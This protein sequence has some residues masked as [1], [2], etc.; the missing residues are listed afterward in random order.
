MLLYSFKKIHVSLDTYAPQEMLLKGFMDR[1]CTTGNSL[2]I[3]ETIICKFGRICQT[4]NAFVWLFAGAPF[5]IVPPKLEQECALLSIWWWLIIVLTQPKPIGKKAP[6]GLRRPSHTAY[7]ISSNLDW[8]NP[9]IP[10]LGPDPHP[11]IPMMPG[12][13]PFFAFRVE[14]QGV[15]RFLLLILPLWTFYYFGLFVLGNLCIL[16]RI[17]KTKSLRFFFSFRKKIFLVFNTKFFKV[18]N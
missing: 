11:P 4:G 3:V 7:A 9:S 10:Q 13:D 6:P 2:M 8:P 14:G 1:M 5:W 16:P 17:F 18:S 15:L 12:Y